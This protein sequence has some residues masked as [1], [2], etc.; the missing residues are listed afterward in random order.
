MFAQLTHLQASPEKI[1]D[2]IKCYYSDTVTAAAEQAGFSG[3]YLL[4]DRASGRMVMVGTWDRE[5]DLTSAETALAP[6]IAR[7]MRAAGVQDQP[8]SERFEVIGQASGNLTA[9]PS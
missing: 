4:A 9:R 7:L 2:T 6:A 5:A 3:G 8:S 1:A